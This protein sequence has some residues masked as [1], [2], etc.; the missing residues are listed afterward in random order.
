MSS[1]RQGAFSPESLIDTMS[2][3]PSVLRAMCAGLSPERVRWKPDAERWSILEVLRHMLDEERE[4]FRPRLCATL[5]SP[6]GPW[7]PIDPA[8]WSRE[9]RYNEADPEETLR[10]FE[11]ERAD[12]L[13]WLRGLVSPDWSHAYV[14]PK[15]GPIHA[16][17]LLLA[18]S[19]HDFLHLRQI[20]KRLYELGLRDG[21]GYSA[22]YAG[23]WT[24]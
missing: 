2:R 24:A 20:C 10:G 17:D 11:R 21:S 19:T 18:W 6:A 16:G 15:F 9:R 1:T 14:H 8:G 12:S 5:E 22:Q 4:D 7:A 3:T 23:E 13:A